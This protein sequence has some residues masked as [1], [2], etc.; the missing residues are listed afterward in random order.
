[1][2]AKLKFSQTSGGSILRLTDNL[3]LFAL[4]YN[5]NIIREFG[6]FIKFYGKIP[7]ISDFSKPRLSDLGKR[8][9]LKHK[10][11]HSD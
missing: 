1:M 4:G 2:L 3:Q 9:K 5:S 10:A 6:D 7:D 8:V 11:N